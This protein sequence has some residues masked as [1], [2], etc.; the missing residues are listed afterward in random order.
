MNYLIVT[1]SI[2]FHVTLL[3]KD[4]V[5]LFDENGDIISINQEA[6]QYRD[7]NWNQINGSSSCQFP[8]AHL[9][10][11]LTMESFK[12]RSIFEV[13]THPKIV[14]LARDV[15]QEKENNIRLIEKAKG[16]LHINAHYRIYDYHS[17]VPTSQRQ[18]IGNLTFNYTDISSENIITKNI[19]DNHKTIV[20][21]TQKDKRNLNLNRLVLFPEYNMAFINDEKVHLTPTEFTILHMLIK[22]PQRNHDL[23]EQIIPTDPF[24]FLKSFLRKLKNIKNHIQINPD[25]SIRLQQIII[26]EQIKDKIILFHDLLIDSSTS[27]GKVFLRGKDLR[28]TAKQFE[29]LHFLASNPETQ[30]QTNELIQG[31]NK[32]DDLYKGITRWTPDETGSIKKKLEEY[33]DLIIVKQMQSLTNPHLKKNLPMLYMFS[34][35]EIEN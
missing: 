4:G 28:F 20:T 3:A 5:V 22:H 33:T 21:L 14:E 29:V 26:D 10:T 1:L 32:R 13:F 18:F 15:L 6:L 31:I 11:L 7:N 2:L 25:G 30:F 35:R 23:S 34:F 12:G 17:Y 24:N 8:F 9:P 16:I 19:S 27:P